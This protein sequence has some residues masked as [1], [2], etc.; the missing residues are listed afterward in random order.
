MA[1]NTCLANL[2]STVATSSA[3]SMPITSSFKRAISHRAWLSTSR[4]HSLRSCGLDLKPIL[5]QA[6]GTARI[7]D[8]DIALAVTCCIVRGGVPGMLDAAASMWVM[9]HE[10]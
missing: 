6:P 10:Y 9:V 2:R 7:R 5:G 1:I 3:R 8:D 4:A